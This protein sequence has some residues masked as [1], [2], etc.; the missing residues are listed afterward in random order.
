MVV[1]CALL[2]GASLGLCYLSG[3]GKEG[4]GHCG[5]GEWVPIHLEVCL[6][7]TTV[8][9]GLGDEP[10]INISD[11]CP[12]SLVTLAQEDGGSG[13]GFPTD[14]SQAQL[15]FLCSWILM[16]GIRSE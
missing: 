1:A 16:W 2:A 3:L 11:P 14:S 7:S 6:G 10:L 8:E 13:Q 9:G 5:G 15:S 4:A 12:L